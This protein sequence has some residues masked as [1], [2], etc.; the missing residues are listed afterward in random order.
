MQLTTHNGIFEAF[1]LLSV[2][3]G[4]VRRMTTAQVPHSYISHLHR[5]CADPLMWIC[6][7]KNEKVCDFDRKSFWIQPH[8]VKLKYKSLVDFNYLI[9]KLWYALIWV[10]PKHFFDSRFHVKICKKLLPFIQM[11]RWFTHCFH[12]FWEFWDLQAPLAM[13]HIKFQAHNPW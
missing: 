9:Q 1:V 12:Q 2:P 8:K 11:N 6:R 7:K 4:P 10:L 13:T 3:A 5:L